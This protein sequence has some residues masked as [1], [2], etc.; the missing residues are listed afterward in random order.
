MMFL[1]SL[2]IDVGE[3]PDR[4]RPGRLWL[5]N[6]YNVHRRL[7]MGFPTQPQRTDDPDFLKPFSPEGFNPPHPAHGAPAAPRFLYRIDTP[8]RHDPARA[9]I[10]VQS[11]E[12]P[13]WDY[14]FNNARMFLAA[15]DTR[16]FNPDFATD[17]V[18]RFRIRM[19]LAKKSHAPKSRDGKVDLRKE[20]VGGESEME[21]RKYDQPKRVSLTWDRDA[22]ETPDQVIRDWFAAKGERCGF[23]LEE[24]H[25]A[26]LGWVRGYRP[27][28][29]AGGDDGG[30]DGDSAAD[31]KSGMKFRSGL[32]EGTLRVT[33]PESLS[34]AVA[35]GIGSAKAFG[36]GLLSLVPLDQ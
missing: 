3:N 30:S 24:F 25:L 6:V 9:V 5:R 29:H 10:L 11:P 20:W 32:L 31:R 14:A 12:R 18:C 8:P 26:H 1:S 23:A 33:D 4:P 34:R 27:K 19:N 35:T 2:M 36:L 17:Q 13:D 22:K 21:R 16:E 15:H 28:F 7:T